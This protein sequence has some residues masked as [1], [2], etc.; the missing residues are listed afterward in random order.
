[1]RILGVIGLAIFLSLIVSNPVAG[2]FFLCEKTDDRGNTVHPDSPQYDLL[3]YNNEL[4][5]ILQ[6]ISS[7]AIIGV[8]ILGILGAIYATV[9]DSMYTPDGDEDSAKYVRMRAG[10][11][12]GG[13]IIPIVLLVGSWVVEWLTEY[14]TTCMISTPLI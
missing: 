5:Y 6:E 11:L 4:V 8:F 2:Q 3:D 10:L 9:K 1:M 14:E 7:L 12:I 13:I